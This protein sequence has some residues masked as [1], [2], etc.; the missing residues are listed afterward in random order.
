[1][2]SRTV[3][4][5]GVGLQGRAVVEDLERRSD[6]EEILAADVDARSLDRWL[7]HL[8]P[9]KTCGLELDARD[10]ARLR[11]VLADGVGLVINMLP[12][13][14]DE[15]VLRAALDARTHLVTTNYGHAVRA[16]D[17]DAARRG[18]TVMPESGFDPGIDLIVAAG[19][20]RDFDRPEILNSYGAGIPA[21]ESRRANAIGYKVSW[22]V[23]GL[24]RSYR[25]PASIL[26]HGAAAEVAGDA[27]FEP[28]WIHTTAFDGFGDLEAFVNGDAVAF[29]DLLGLRSSVRHAARFS[30]R[31]PGH[32]EFW[33]T[34][35]ALGLLDEQ[36]TPGMGVSPRQFLAHHLETRL[37]YGPEE[38]DAVLMRIDLAGWK[39]GARTARR[40]E[41]TRF[42]DPGSELLAMSIVTGYPASIIAQMI[43]S[44]EVARPGVG[45]P[46]RDVPLGPFLEAL[47]SRGITIAEQ[48]IDPS[49]CV[50]LAFPS[51]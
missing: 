30:L 27:I 31:W 17:R 34:V 28:A 50:R 8:G 38:R 19:A 39:D 22:S 33:R 3:L 45:C 37:Q 12:V 40:L 35:V 20:A 49:E 32:C 21:P 51:A 6:V 23:E 24:L 7:A 13:S 29:V 26:H 15:H 11:R 42:R 10:G 4:V 2:P 46:A 18:I 48:D 44:G 14:F 5:L 9:S 16:F 36:P 25:R 1:M 41:M 43:L 47:R